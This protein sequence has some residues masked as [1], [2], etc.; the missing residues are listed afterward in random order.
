MNA[1][2]TVRYE[3]AVCG[4]DEA[5]Q[6]ATARDWGVVRA[7]G[8][9]RHYCPACRGHAARMLLPDDLVD[10]LHSALDAARRAVEDPSGALAVVDDLRTFLAALGESDE[11]EEE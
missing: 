8:V 6:W 4:A 9:E 5:S 10:G 11:N 1:G 2:N 7:D 3:C